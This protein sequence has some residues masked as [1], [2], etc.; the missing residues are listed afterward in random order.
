MEL[1]KEKKDKLKKLAAISSILLATGLCCLKGGAFYYTNSLAVF[2]SMIDSLSDVFAS[3]ITFFAVRVS[4]RPATVNYRYGYGKVEALSALFQSLFVVASGGFVL[5]D[6]MLRIKNPVVIEQTTEGL[7]VMAISLIA[8]I[9]LVLFQRKV[10]KITESQAI[11]ADSMHYYVDILTNISIIVSL[12]SINLFGVFWVDTL[13]AI[14]I[15]V[16]LLYNAY[17]MGRDAVRLL[18]DKELSEDIR[19]RIFDIVTTHSSNLQIHDLRTRSAGNFYMFEFHLEMDG[20]MSLNEAHKYTEEIET[21][22]CQEYPD[23]Q[24]I[25]HQDPIGIDERRLDNSLI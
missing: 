2:S 14:L 9:V 23:A 6:S 1:S 20:N 19:K 12:F 3:L 10:A 8:T 21:L 24:V 22:I 5:Y 13:V 7:V 25:I 15:S 4:L 18:L 17:D 16:Y 11:L